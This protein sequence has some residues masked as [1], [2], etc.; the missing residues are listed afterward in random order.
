MSSFPTNMC[1]KS[2]MARVPGCILSVLL[3][4][5]KL[6]YLNYMYMSIKVPK[7]PHLT[8]VRPLFTLSNK[9]SDNSPLLILYWP[10]K[11]WPEISSDNFFF[12]I[13]LRSYLYLCYFIEDLITLHYWS[14]SCELCMT[15]VF[16]YC[17]MI[18]TNQLPP[19]WIDL[20]EASDSCLSWW[21]VDVEIHC[22]NQ[23][24]NPSITRGQWMKLETWKAWESTRPVTIY[25]K[26]RLIYKIRFLI[27][28]NGAPHPILSKIR[29]M[30]KIPCVFFLIGTLTRIHIATVILLNASCSEIP[31]ISHIYPILVLSLR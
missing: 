14:C 24:T 5:Q 22:C 26:Q 13:W 4:L 2:S 20:C 17:I 23:S 28:I 15:F 7:N 10:I 21:D 19:F 31:S 25:F 30:D 12:L 27:I 1:E 3:Y 11:S 18:L 6:D 29:L 8:N 16:A 9:E